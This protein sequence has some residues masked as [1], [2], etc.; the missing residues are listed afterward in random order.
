MI[1]RILLALIFA[2]LTA[3]PA[4]AQLGPSTNGPAYAPN[5]YTGYVPTSREWSLMWSNK[6]DYNVNGLPIL[7][8]GTGANNAAAAR[9]NLGLL[10]NALTS[11]QI[12]V[13]S[14]ANIATARAL[15][16]DAALTNLGGLTVSNLSHVTNASLPNSGLVSAAT[17]VNGQTCTLGSTCTVTAVAASID[18]AGATAI[19]NGATNGVLY[20]T[21]A[22]KVGETASVNSAV[23]ISSGA[24]LPSFST[25]LPTGLSASAFTV[26][27]SFTATGLVTLADH[28]TQATNTVIGNATS[29]T[30]SPTALA[31]TSCSTSSSA[32]S[33]TTNTGF[34]CNTS[35][36]AATLGG[37]A[38]FAAPGAIGG[39]TPGA[40]TFTTLNV[41]SNTVLSGT[42]TA[43]S[44]STVGTVAGALCATSGGLILYE[45]GVNCFGG[46]VTTITVAS[47]NGFAGSSSGGATPALTLSTSITGMLKGNGT[48]ISAGTAGT[49][50]AAPGSAMTVSALYTFT[51]SD[52]AL[53]GSSTGKTTF[54]SANAGA[55]NFTLTFPA[56][57]DTLAAIGT[58]QTWTAVQT[59]NNSGIRLL[60][61]STGYTAFTSANAGA[62]NFTLTLPAVTDTV[63]TLGTASQV[64]AGGVHLTAYSIGTVSSGTTT[65][66]CGN[67]P[68]QYL[69]NGGAFTLAAPSNDSSCLVMATN[70]GS[71]GAI[72]FSGFTVG[73]STGDALTT[74]NTNKFTISIWRINGTSGYRIAAM[75]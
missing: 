13:G 55:S 70:N 18:A 7:Y 65:I 5:W 62:S 1:K 38:T 43:A 44:L 66:D 21:S 9:T 25:T 67:N 63:A 40:A 75:Q 36:N 49:D 54:T 37:S 69:T 35:I 32:V 10:G 24:G 46:T 52:I 22:G 56:A 45:V 3:F 58:A 8:G 29:G 12:Y 71:A 73:S 53:L 57:T 41:N 2:T 27:G 6:L 15:S 39:G 60:G 51:N 50:Y 20:Q 26:T 34:G 74:T 33:W 48:A 31:M 14:S 30:A 72:T 47:A 61:S 17:T 28:A 23:L 4:Q 68:V 11:G 59:H 64:M 19:T 42:L 16:G